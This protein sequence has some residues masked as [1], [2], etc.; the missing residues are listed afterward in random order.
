MILDKMHDPVQASVY[1]PAVI[2]RI[3]EILSSRTFLIFC[4]M[5]GMLDQFFNSFILRS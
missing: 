3:T 4:H 1:C 5:H 2:V